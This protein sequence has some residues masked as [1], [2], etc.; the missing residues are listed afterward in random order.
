MMLVRP[1]TSLK[2]VHPDKRIFLRLV[3]NTVDVSEWNLLLVGSDTVKSDLIGEGF[4]RVKEARLS[5]E[6]LQTK[7]SIWVM[8]L[9]R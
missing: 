2:A 8:S 6:Q 3:V 4:R 5:I 7:T 9:S 1:T